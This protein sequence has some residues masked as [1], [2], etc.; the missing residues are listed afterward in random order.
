MGGLIK[1]SIARKV[2]MALS[3]L[4]LVFFLL[5]HFTI[6]FTSIFSADTFN[7]LSHFMGTN[8]LVQFVLQPVL[9]FGVVFHFVM[10]FVLEI[11]NKNARAIKYAKYNGGANAS[12]M[13]R[14]MIYSGLVILAFLGLHFY[15]FW[16]PEIVHKYVEFAPEDPTRYYSELLHKFES[17]IRTGLYALS[18][19]FLALHLWHG[20]A[21]SFQSV[22]FNNKYSIAATKFAK[23]FAIVIPVGFIII[24]IVLHF[25]H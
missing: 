9:I 17:P 18:F 20:F 21:S 10:G 8:P 19:V 24:A 12:W 13:S 25:T 2:A 6:N 14:N 7:E 23:A 5:Q 4:F 1:S 15:D 3:G 16:V 22:G 11:K